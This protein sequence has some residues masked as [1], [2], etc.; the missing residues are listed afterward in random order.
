MAKKTGQKP[1]AKRVKVT[2]VPPQGSLNF[3]STA[4]PL[5]K[6]ATN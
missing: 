1:A 5:P 6:P 3:V 4:F 2:L